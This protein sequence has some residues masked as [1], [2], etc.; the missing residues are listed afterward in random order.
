M[1]RGTVAPGAGAYLELTKPGITGFVA[2]SAAVGFALGA[3]SP[4]RLDPAALAARPLD[5]L[6]TIAGTALAAG[7]TNALNQW[8]ERRADGRM[9]RT[10]RR[11]LPDGRVA[12]GAALAFGLL[13]AA[14]GPALLLA[15]DVVAAAMA[16]ATVVLYDLVY[17]PL[18]RRTWLSTVVGSVPG[19]LPVL[20]GWQAGAGELG[21]GAWILFAILF[22][23]Q[24]PHFFSLDWLCRE[25]YR[26]GGFRTLA[27]TD[28]SGRASAAAAIGSALLLAGATLLPWVAG[29]MGR[30]YAGA[31]GALGAGIVGLALPLGASLTR[32]RAHRLFAGSLVYLPAVYLLLLVGAAPW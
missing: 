31:A 3:G 17:T 2:L 23:W 24:L 10:R 9:E 25:D 18:K 14:A 32:R 11:P 6:G 8:I 21:P 29:G 19:A 4:W 5:V 15:V 22:L 27:T 30:L 1:E 28:R 7:G 20:G 16:A 26:R 13:L 12:P